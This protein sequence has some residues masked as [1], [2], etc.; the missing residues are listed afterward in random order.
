MSFGL[1]VLL[2]VVGTTIWVGVDASKRDWSAGGGSGAN[3]TAGWVIACLLLWI[4]FFPMY[5]VKRGRAPL[6]DAPACPAASPSPPD[7]M[8][9]ECP[10]CKEPMRRDAAICP[11]CREPSTAWRLHDGR[12]WF[13]ASSEDAWQWLDE[14]SGSWVPLEAAPVGTP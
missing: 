11:H 6:K 8:Y 13:R 3:S 7:A 4:L 12:W 2:I 9:R 14:R 5:L 1:L 10:Y